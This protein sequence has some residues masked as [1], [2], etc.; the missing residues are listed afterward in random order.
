MVAGRLGGLGDSLDDAGVGAHEEVIVIIEVLDGLISKVVE[1]ETL[2]ANLV[3]IRGIRLRTAISIRGGRTVLE[4]ATRLGLRA[5][6]ARRR[7]KDVR[8][9]GHRVGLSRHS[10]SCEHVMQTT[11]E[12]VTFG[13]LLGI[14]DILLARTTQIG[15]RVV[16]KGF[17]GEQVDLLIVCIDTTILRSGSMTWATLVASM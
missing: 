14:G 15:G 5:F 17:E 3:G 9:G 12:F 16:R 10:G 4:Q 6:S 1:A 7:S 11:Q 13:T 2:L 8:I